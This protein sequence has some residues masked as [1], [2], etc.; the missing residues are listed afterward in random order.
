MPS[1]SLFLSSV[2]LAHCRLH[3]STCQMFV[4]L[5]VT[6]TNPAKMAKKI[7]GCC[8]RC[9]FVHANT[10]TYYVWLQTSAPGE[11]DWMMWVQLY[12][13]L[14]WPLVPQFLQFSPSH[15]TNYC[16][17]TFFIPWTI[18]RVDTLRKNHKSVQK[19]RAKIT[20]WTELSTVLCPTQHKIGHFRDILSS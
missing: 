10:T 13:I 14:L 7:L 19:S 16:C 4:Y 6:P 11:H 9:R 8:S 15:W 5:L 2:S 3:N 20:S 17:I 12:V 1:L 18:K